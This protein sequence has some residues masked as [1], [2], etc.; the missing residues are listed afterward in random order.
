MEGQDEIAVQAVE[1]S[2]FF[3]DWFFNMF[4]AVM[5]LQIQSPTFVLLFIGILAGLVILRIYFDDPVQTLGCAGLYIYSI[6][7]SY[8]LFSDSIYVIETTEEGWLMT[9]KAMWFAFLFALILVWGFSKVI[10]FVYTQLLA[11]GLGSA[12]SYIN[13]LKLLNLLRSSDANLADMDDDFNAGSA[14][15]PKRQNTAIMMTDI[16]GFSKQMGADA[17]G[18]GNT[19]KI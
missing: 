10:Q 5:E 13:P 3:N 17:G 4:A 7:Q 1:S 2:G 15:D 12:L 11:V 14:K 9:G 16:V 19:F 18:G 6:I 8:S